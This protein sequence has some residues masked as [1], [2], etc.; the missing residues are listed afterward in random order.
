MQAKGKTPEGLKDWRTRKLHPISFEMFQKWIDE[1]VNKPYY[2]N[3]SEINPEDIKSKH[4]EIY[5]FHNITE[6]KTDEELEALKPEK[7]SWAK[8]E[9]SK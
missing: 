2:Y 5:V 9:L 7:P 3:L 4:Q 6:Y 1:P 8:L